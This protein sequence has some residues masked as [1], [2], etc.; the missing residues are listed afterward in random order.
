M[1]L[2]AFLA[3]F[4]FSLWSAQLQLARDLLAVHDREPK[5]EIA[6]DRFELFALC[7]FVDLVSPLRSFSTPKDRGHVFLGLR[8]DK[9]AIEVVQGQVYAA[10]S[11]LAFQT[12]TV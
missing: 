1:I 2:F 12:R 8:G 10:I 6:S 4:S 5:A 3:P 7:D 11:R 9:S